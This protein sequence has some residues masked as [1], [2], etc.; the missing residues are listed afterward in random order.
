MVAVG[1]AGA[2]LKVDAAVAWDPDMSDAVGK[3]AG[4]KK[5]YDTK[6]ANRLIADILV[7]G[8]LP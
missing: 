4:S 3:R 5:I 1:A 7:V 2:W 6:I 8:F